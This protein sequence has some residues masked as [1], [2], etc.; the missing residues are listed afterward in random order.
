MEYKV[1]K[2]ELGEE[3]HYNVTYHENNELI[4]S[5]CWFGT[6]QEVQEFITELEKG[7]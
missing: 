2:V 3:T 4:A 7:Y 1:T 5:S 6:A